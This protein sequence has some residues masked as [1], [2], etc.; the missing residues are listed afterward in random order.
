MRFWL[1]SA[2]ICIVIF[3]SETLLSQTDDKD[4]TNPITITDSGNQDKSHRPKKPSRQIITC[5]YQNG[6]MFFR[7]TVDEGLCDVTVT[8][9]KTGMPQFFEIDSSEDS[10]IYVG[11]LETASIVIN[12]E[13]GNTYSGEF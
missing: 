12:T 6:E 10:Y 13:I 9:L 11:N 4:K 3:N 2:L 7:F 8:D 1:L 5:Y